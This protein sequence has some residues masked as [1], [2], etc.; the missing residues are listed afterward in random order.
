VKAPLDIGVSDAIPV[1]PL[2]VSS[3]PVF[4]LTCTDP[5]STLSGQ[6]FNVTGPGRALISGT[7]ADTGKAKDP[8]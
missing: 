4:A 8:I 1:P 7:C 3:L 6:A 2:E 5:G